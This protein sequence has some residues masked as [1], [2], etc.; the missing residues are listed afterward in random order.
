MLTLF[1]FRTATLLLANA[2]QRLGFDHTAPFYFLEALVPLRDEHQGTPARKIDPDVAQAV[3]PATL[4]AHVVPTLLMGVLPMT[5]T[6]VSRAPYGLQSL[7]CHAFLYSPFTV[8]ALTYGLVSLRKWTRYRAN[9]RASPGQRR[10]YSHELIDDDDDD[11]NNNN[12]NDGNY[13]TV[14]GRRSIAG[15]KNAYTDLVSVQ[16]AGHVLAVATLGIQAWRM[17]EKLAAAVPGAS[18]VAKAQATLQWVLRPMDFTRFE[19]LGLYVAATTSMGLYTVW[20]LR[21]RGYAT[22][23]AAGTAAAGLVLGQVLVGPGASYAGLW[24]WR[25][26]VLA[27]LPPGV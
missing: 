3:L 4:L 25:E 14:G 7:V 6:D 11:N 27:G 22:T 20:D 17:W 26:G 24:M 10:L 15:L 16:A 13:Y 19:L 2:L 5:F 18:L 23:R 21:R 8:P 1:F 12:I 9:L